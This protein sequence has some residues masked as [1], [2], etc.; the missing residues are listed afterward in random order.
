MMKNWLWDTCILGALAL[1]W[2][3]FPVAGQGAERKASTNPS[4]PNLKPANLRNQT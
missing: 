1:L 2:L 4:T 3:G